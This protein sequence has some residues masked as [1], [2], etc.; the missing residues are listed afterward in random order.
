MRYITLLLFILCCNIGFCQLT[1]RGNLNGSIYF[2]ADNGSSWQN[3]SNGIPEGI[4][5]TDMAVS[6]DLLGVSTKQDGIFL[7]NSQKND[8][9]NVSTQPWIKNN[10]DALYFFDNKIYA[11]TQNGG[12]YVSSDN[13]ETWL[14]INKGL[15]NLTIRK[16]AAFQ[17]KLYAGTNGGLYSLN[18]KENKWDLEFGKEGLQVNGMTEFAGELYIG[19]NRGAYK[20]LKQTNNWHEIMSN[21][22]LHNISAN[23]HAI[24]AM[25]YNELYQTTDKGTSWKNIQQGLPENLYTFQLVTKDNVS[26]AG[27][28]H[29]VYKKINSGPPL[30]LS[31][32]WKSSDNGLPS[33]YSVTEMKIFKNILV[34]GCTKRG[35]RNENSSVVQTKDY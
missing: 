22:S 14:Q 8:W 28:W 2:S 19:T 27:Q 9:E 13:G 23:D 17:N 33:E 25:V 11:G 26:F 1:E 7:Y 32:E 6:D 20:F 21:C 24:Y 18:E 16:L 10:I 34:I 5:I 12:M 15:G 31:G 4:F 35:L 30:Y 29:G 3:H